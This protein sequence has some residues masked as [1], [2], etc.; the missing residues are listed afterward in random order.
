M[1]IARDFN[2]CSRKTSI[3]MGVVV[4]ES[5]SLVALWSYTSLVFGEVIMPLNGAKVKATTKSTT[6]KTKK[7]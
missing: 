2:K 1:I 6:R 5:L 7:R 4:K 3:I